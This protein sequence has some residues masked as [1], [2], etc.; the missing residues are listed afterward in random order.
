MIH[1]TAIVS[2]KARI[3]QNVE[4]G[5]FAIIDDDVEIGE[6]TKIGPKV[7]IINGARIGKNNYIGEG[8]LISDAPQDLKY[9]GAPTQTIIGDNNVIREYVTIHRATGE[10]GKT[11]VGNNNFLMTGSHIAHECSLGNNVIIVNNTAIAGHVRIDDYAF[12]SGLCAIHQHCRI[13]GHTML[14]GGSTLTQDIAP[15][16]MAAT[17]EEGV[18][19]INKL[20]LKR[21]GFSRERIAALEDSYQIFFKAK[22]SAKEALDI[23][24]G[25]Y[26]GNEDVGYFADFI[27]SSKR[28]ILR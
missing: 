20:G 16:T 13:G 7:H 8:S 11:L 3:A 18:F 17:R 26:P 2:A 19:G 28:G 5:P 15:F 6:G 12:I 9:T 4:V 14:G 21:R 25:K 24:R 22:I 1:N 27:A 10:G 23:M